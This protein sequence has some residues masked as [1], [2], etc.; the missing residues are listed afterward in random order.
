MATITTKLV[1]DGNS[2]AVRLHSTVLA[3][4]G[5]QD[6]VILEVEK[7]RVTIRPFNSKPR[8][9]WPRLIEQEIARNPK[10]LQQSDTELD[11]WNVTI[12][13]GLN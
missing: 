1:K 2:K 7:G 13:D 5:L 12:N 3:M 4:S 6:E 9:N 11:D 8:S 10:S